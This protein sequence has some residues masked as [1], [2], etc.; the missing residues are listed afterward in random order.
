MGES[1]ALILPTRWYEGFPMSIVESYSVGTPVLASDLG[2]AGS[3]VEEGKSGLKFRADSPED[4][5][6]ALKQADTVLSGL[7]DG[8]IN[9]YSEESNY[10]QLRK[11][12][13]ACCDHNKYSGTLS[14]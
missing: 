11:I 12:Y 13:E 9:Q 10:E 2:N 3:L 5:C 7:E 4:L 8:I 14:G 1:K 6:R